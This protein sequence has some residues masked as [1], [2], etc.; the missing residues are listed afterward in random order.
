MA[1]W[2][3]GH[4]SGVAQI[5][6]ARRMRT[7]AVLV[8]IAGVAGVA[9]RLA[10]TRTVADGRVMEA[11]FLSLFRPKGVIGMVCDREIP[12]GRDGALFAC[13][14]VLTDGT[15]QLLDCAMSRDGKLTASAA[16]GP[17]S[18]ARPRPAA[19]PKPEDPGDDGIRIS[20][21]PWAN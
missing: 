4:E 19:A 20:R 18:A 7:L 12:V 13:T 2:I 6:Y 14:A 16:G 3:S 10:R 5:R 11:E 8:F 9:V 15:E 17:R 21:D 1:I